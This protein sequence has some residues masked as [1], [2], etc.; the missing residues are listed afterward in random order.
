VTATARVGGPLAACHELGY[1]P[2]PESMEGSAA[3]LSV[4][5]PSRMMLTSDAGKPLLRSGRHCAMPVRRDGLW[6]RP[7]RA[8][9]D[10]LWHANDRIHEGARELSAAANSSSPPC[11]PS[12]VWGDS[13]HEQHASLPM[14]VAVLAI[15]S[16]SPRGGGF[17]SG[18]RQHVLATSFDITGSSPTVSASSESIALSILRRARD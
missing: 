9:P 16:P 6:G 2:L 12:G 3:N 13:I 18:A 15:R 4:Y 1:L 8:G 11:S 14:G 10:A 17:A 5:V 7:Q